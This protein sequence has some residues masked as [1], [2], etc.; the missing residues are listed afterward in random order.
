MRPFRLFQYNLPTTCITRELD[1]NVFV[2]FLWWVGGILG[3]TEFNFASDVELYICSL[4]K[5]GLELL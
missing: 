3:K 1:F 4:N 2:S 5:L